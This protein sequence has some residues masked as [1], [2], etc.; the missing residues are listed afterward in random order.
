[1][2]NDLNA[3]A[4]QRLETALAETGARDPRQAYRTLLRKL[5]QRD[6][7]AYARAVTRWRTAVIEPLGRGEGEPLSLWLSFG[8][9]LVEALHPG[10]AVRIDGGGIAHTLDGPPGWDALVLHLPEDPRER[11]V[12]VVLPPAPSPAQTATLD[13]LVEGRLSLDNA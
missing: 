12:P 3:R 8:V 9:E 1:M 10:R 4:D 7:A 11:A 13:L 2:S 6:E 5:K